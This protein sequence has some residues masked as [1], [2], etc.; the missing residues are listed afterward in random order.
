MLST[1]KKVGPMQSIASKL[2]GRSVDASGPKN[3]CIKS[4]ENYVSNMIRIQ[5]PYWAGHVK[6]INDARIPKGTN[7]KTEEK[8]EMTRSAPMVKCY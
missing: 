8:E 1:F 4:L 3:R 7:R 5:R 2:R 6:R